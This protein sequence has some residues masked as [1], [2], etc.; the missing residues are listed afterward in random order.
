MQRELRKQ[1]RER[2]RFRCEYCRLPESAMLGLAFQV[3]HVRARQH[4]GA[5]DECNLG[6]ACPDCNQFKGP[7]QSAY[8]PE[9]NTLVRLFNPRQDAWD[10]H[11][12]LVQ[13]E[14]VGRSPIGRATVELLQMNNADRVELRTIALANAIW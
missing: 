3:E 5:D 4:R 14:I 2:A 7:N 8:D 1:V 10:E 13:A 9:S 6:L 11:F 12:L